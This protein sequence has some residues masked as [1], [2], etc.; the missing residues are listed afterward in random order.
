M[1]KGTECESEAVV[2][3]NL[4]MGTD[5][6]KTVYQDDDKM[7][8]DRATGH[9]DIDSELAVTKHEVKHTID[10]KTCADF[11]SFPI[12]NPKQEKAYRWQGQVYMRLK[13]ED[14]KQHTVAR[15]LV[16]TPIWI[17]RSELYNIASRCMKQYEW[18]EKL[19]DKEIDR[20]SRI[21]FKNNVYDQNVEV[22]CNGRTLK[23]TDD[24]VIPYK[25]RVW[26]WTF[27]RDDKA[28]DELREKVAEINNDILP[29][30]LP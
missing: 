29:T 16:N 1:A 8:N 12:L 19:C 18:N 13:W 7:E 26:T 27:Y 23:L 11:N 28:I 21:Y 4:A 6:K 17:I 25:D 10:I 9:E 30:R 3:Y 22:E 2:I 15:V 5:Y 14:Y 20:L 24:L